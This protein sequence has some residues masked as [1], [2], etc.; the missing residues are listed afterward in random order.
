MASRKHVLTA[1]W[2]VSRRVVKVW[3]EVSEKHT[4]SFFRVTVWVIW[5]LKSLRT[6]WPI[7]ATKGVVGGR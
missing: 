6:F 5:V 7:T 4:A 1:L 3:C 2:G